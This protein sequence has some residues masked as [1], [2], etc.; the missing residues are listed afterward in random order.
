MSTPSLPIPVTLYDTTGF[1]NTLG[2]TLANIHTL[3]PQS[4]T[5]DYHGLGFKHLHNEGDVGP[6]HLHHEDDV[7][8]KHPCNEDDAGHQHLRDEDNAGHQ[9]LRHEDNSGLKHP[10]E[11]DTA[12][13]RT[14]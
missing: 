4:P 6:K 11:D 13:T 12:S 9:H 5:S 10:L 14:A 2:N 3:R 7:G 1:G 8:P